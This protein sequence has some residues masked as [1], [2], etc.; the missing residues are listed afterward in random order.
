MSRIIVYLLFFALIAGCTYNTIPKKEIEDMKAQYTL[1]YGKNPDLWPI[2]IGMKDEDTDIFSVPSEN[3][4][5]TNSLNNAITLLRFDKDKIS[6]DEVRKDF[7]DGVG[8]GDKFYPGIFSDKWIGY[9]QTRGFL[10]FNLADKS[11][12]DNIPIKSGDEY[13]TGIGV[14]DGPKLQFLFQVRDDRFLESKRFLRLFEFDGKGG[15]KQISEIQA[16]LHKISYLEPW[17]IQNKTIFVYNNDSIKIIA[18]DVNFRTVRHPFCELFN[19][20]R[21]FKCLGE[22]A[23]H[24]SLPFAVLVENDTNENRVWLARWTCP[25]EDERSVELVGQNISMFSE[26]ADIK[27]LICSHFQFSPDGKWLVFQDNSEIAIQNVDNPTFVAMPV[28]GDNPMFLGK[29]KILGKV[30]RENARPTST[31]W[32]SKPLSFVASDGKVLYKWEL[33]SLKRDF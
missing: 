4:V 10:L 30:M 25:E 24:P 13:F 26:W 9:T 16:G 20:L 3:A 12:A 2:M 17:T 28:D 31:A 22:F 29:P 19:S 5:G 1:H 6:Y 21:H 32:I 14:I 11:F 33:N 7:I 18:Y 15:F 8:S 27:H 23:I